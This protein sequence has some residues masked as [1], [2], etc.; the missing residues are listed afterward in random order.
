LANTGT[1]DA[2]YTIRC[3]SQNSAIAVGTPGTVL[4]GKTKRLYFNNLGCPSGADSVEF[5]L[6]IA[7]GNVVGSVVRMNSTTGDSAFE[8]LTGN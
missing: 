1:L 2:T 5:T 3:L 6:A 7:Q 8:A 4:A